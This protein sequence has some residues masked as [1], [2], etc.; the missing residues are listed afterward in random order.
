MVRS[1]SCRG[2]VI[3]DD[4]DPY[5]LQTQLEE[6]RQCLLEHKSAASISIEESFGSSP[7]HYSSVTL[8]SSSGWCCSFSHPQQASLF[9]L[10]LY[11]PCGVIVINAP[12]P[13]PL[14]YYA[15]HVAGCFPY[16]NFAPHYWAVS[17]LVAVHYKKYCHFLTQP[18]AVYKQITAC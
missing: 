15:L 7:Q 17:L 9:L 2:P 1:L 12:L 16:N 3:E 10:L 18:S 14:K 6:L 4:A 13:A 8:Q 5:A 11:H